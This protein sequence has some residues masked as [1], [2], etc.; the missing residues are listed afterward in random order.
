MKYTPYMLHNYKSIRQ[1]QSVSPEII[2]AIEVVGS[3]LPFKTNNYVV[4]NLIDWN[5]IPDDPMFKLTFPQKEMLIPEHFTEMASAIKNNVGKTQIKEIANKI[6]LELNPHPAGQIEYNVP[7]IE[8]EKIYGMQ[9]KYRETVLFFPSQGQTCHAYCTFC[10]RW[11]QFVG[12]ED[13]KFASREVELLV[14][15]VKEHKEV[16]DVLF[17]G[18]DPLIMK[19]TH[20]ETYI[21]ALLDADI[22]NLRH[23]RIGTKS[24]SYWPYR[25]LTDTDADDLLRLFEEVKGAGK[26]LAIMAHFNHPAELKSDAVTKAIKRILK[27]G[28]VIRTQ[29]PILR[30]INDSATVWG[31]MLRRQIALGC[32]P[33]YMFIVRNTGAQHYFSIP[34]VEA[35]HIFQETYQSISGI[36]R[37]LRG[38]S[39]SCIPGKIQ[40][41]GV[42]DVKG[43]KALALRMIQGRNPDW[44]ARPFFAKYDEKATWY[45]ELKPAFGE[46]KFFFSDELEKRLDTDALEA[47]CE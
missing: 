20:L 21:R 7:S 14:K 3:V 44:V 10:F 32:I 12:I 47:G 28:A 23:I 36:C 37:T 1:L 30:H 2:E 9:H 13:L 27:T 43:E 17:T 15:Y 25:F 29:S 22:P 8:G 16:T 46:E 45:N 24:L 5:N 6:R 31:N 19:T 41:L 42:A 33:Y 40:I 4:N 26:H 11:P 38:P 34:L 35:W 18:G 39:M